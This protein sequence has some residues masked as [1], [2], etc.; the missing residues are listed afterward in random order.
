MEHKHFQIARQECHSHK[1]TV[2]LFSLAC[3]GHHAS[4]DICWKTRRHWTVLARDTH[5]PTHISTQKNMY[6]PAHTHTH[7]STTTRTMFQRHGQAKPMPSSPVAI[8]WLVLSQCNVTHA[9]NCLEHCIWQL[10]VVHVMN[11][12]MPQ[13]KSIFIIQCCTLLDN[14]THV[15]THTHTML[16][17]MRPPIILY[18]RTNWS[19]QDYT[20]A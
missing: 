2:F 5:V 13:A 20:Q 12:H 6:T 9:Q 7:Q 14:S 1:Y 15:H 11:V 8:A 18:K 3:M 19:Y 4:N 10:F 17:L 16:H